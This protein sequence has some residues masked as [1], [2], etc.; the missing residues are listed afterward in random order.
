ME[1]IEEFKKNPKTGSLKLLTF[2]DLD[3]SEMNSK[4]GK[5]QPVDV[6]IINYAL[7]QQYAKDKGEVFFALNKIFRNFTNIAKDMDLGDDHKN[8]FLGRIG[9]TVSAPLFI[10]KKFRQ[11][12]HDATFPA[13]LIG[14]WREPLQDLVKFEFKDGEVIEVKE[15]SEDKK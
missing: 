10:L 5:L 1:D 11:K 6:D 7:E 2:D 13:R 9:K 14:G 15:D 3:L 8:T 4:F 12:M